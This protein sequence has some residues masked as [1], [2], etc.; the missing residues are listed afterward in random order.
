MIAMEKGQYQEAVDS[1]R[2]ALDLNLRAPGLRSS[3]AQA[4]M[5][6][7][8]FDEAM[9]ELQQ[10]IR[11][12][13]TSQTAHFLA[14]QVFLQKKDYERACEKY[15]KV[16]E[17]AP[18][19]TNSYYGLVTVSARLGEKDRVQEYTEQFNRCKARDTQKLIDDNKLVND[20]VR[21]R[22]SYAETAF[23]AAR[24]YEQLGQ[25]R[26]TAVLLDKAVQASNDNPDLSVRIA[27]WHYRRGRLAESLALHEAIAKAHPESGLNSFLLGALYAQTK[28]FDDAR[29]SFMSSIEY[30]PESA[31]AYR[32]LARLNLHTRKDIAHAKI[33]AEKAVSLAPVAVNYFILSRACDTNGDRQGALSALEKAVE[34]DPNNQEYR[35][36][37]GIIAG[38]KE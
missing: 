30:S 32:E 29:E 21:A 38:R 25:V 17:L 12:Y 11:L 2:K 26:E 22:H 28:R 27:Q 33:L 20:L 34:L 1:W 8:K 6:L 13:P 24:L 15:L 10:Q 4:L 9:A 14:G 7:G 23:D 19:H 37:Y 18:D 36:I 31:D 5:R 35:R 16:L 3:I